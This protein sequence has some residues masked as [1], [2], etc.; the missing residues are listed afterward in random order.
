[1][2]K[3]CHVWISRVIYQ[4]VMSRMNESCH[5]WLSHIPHEWVMSHMNESYPIF[6]SKV[7]YEIHLTH[8]WVITHMNESYHIWISCVT[9]ECASHIWMSHVKYKWGMLYVNESC[10]SNTNEWVMSHMI[11]WF[12]LA[13]KRRG[14]AFSGPTLKNLNGAAAAGSR[15]WHLQIRWWHR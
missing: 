13:W 6:M 14:P 12:R 5:T 8:E 7:T 9:C 2:N 1:M 10:R 4:W 15:R 3:S 11:E